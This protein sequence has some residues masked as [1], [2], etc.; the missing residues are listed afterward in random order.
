MQDESFEINILKLNWIDH[1]DNP[2]DLCAHGTVFI[3]IANT[4][5]VNE[6]SG[7]QWTLSAAALHL[8]RTIENDYKPGNFAGQLIPCCGFFLIANDDLN[9]VKICGCPSGYDW[10]VQHIGNEIKLIAS[11]GE[12]AILKTEVYKE[13]ILSFADRVKHFYDRSKP[14]ILPED[15]FDRN[16]YQAFWT[17]WQTL[18]SRLD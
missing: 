4:I 13:L 5:V 3:R 10:D 7:D 14:K 9:Q 2:A 11:T 15:E 12:Q 17:E 8:M 1:T 6:S 16:G 18:R